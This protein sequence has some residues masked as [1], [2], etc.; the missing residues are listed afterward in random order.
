MKPESGHDMATRIFSLSLLL[1]FA[2]AASGQSAADAGSIRGL[3]HNEDCTDFFFHRPIPPGKSAETL[4]RY[5]D[6]L[7]DAGI[8]ALFCN[9]NARRVN[10]R[11]DVWPAFWDG[12]DPDGPDD[13]PYFLPI[14]AE[15]RKT[16][17]LLVHNMWQVH[18]EGIDY[19]ARVIARCRQRGISPWI[20]LRMNDVHFNS[21]LAHPFHDEL[22][23]KP[24]FFRKNHPG[25]YSRALDY[26]HPEVRDHFRKLIAETLQRFDADGLELDFMREPYLF[27]AGREKAGAALLT[28]WLG[29]IRELV[30][31]AARRRGHPIRLSVRV[32]S[33]PAVAVGLGLDAPA[34]AKAGLVDLVVPSP[35]WRTLQFDIP[36]KQ[37]RELLGKEVSLAGGLETRYQPA[38]SGYTRGVTPE[39]TAGA[40]LAVWSGGADALYLF[41]HFQNSHP[42]WSAEVYQRMLKACG[43]PE[44]LRKLP[45]L[46]A[47]THREVTI[48]GEKYRPPLP[49][50]G[51]EHTFNLPLGPRPPSDWTAEAFISAGDRK[52]K[53]S[54]NGVQGKWSAS[55]GETKLQKYYFPAGAVS[56]DG[57]DAI[58]VGSADG[59]PIRIDR[60]EIRLAPPGVN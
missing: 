45:R 57:D 3:L 53:V 9:V 22:W 32:P 27:S 43:S 59:E 13:Q 36:I 35:R 11:S 40:A 31:Q 18:H 14:P 41:N 21:N 55:D 51:T 58:K 30:D 60:V 33:Q 37:W 50:T 5:I 34:W 4:D 19:P 10:Y 17:R 52:L 42:H 47:V 26:A 28:A 25:Y 12:Y 49:A 1:L 16:W 7:A 48:P 8:S 15:Q 39:H 54:V 20:S 29:E 46:H 2:F 44:A 24:E 6:V 23:R 56:G 38:S